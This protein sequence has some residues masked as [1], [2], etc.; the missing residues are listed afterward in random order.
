MLTKNS[1]ESKEEM[2]FFGF[3]KWVEM[4]EEILVDAENLCEKDNTP[5]TMLL[6]GFWRNRNQ[7]V[8]V[9]DQMVSGA[10]CRRA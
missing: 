5:E 10:S 9:I 8:V 4:L 7:I 6:T 1:H 3:N 2:A